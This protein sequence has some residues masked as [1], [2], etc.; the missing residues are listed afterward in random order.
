MAK[1]LKKK[2]MDVMEDFFSL[3]K[4]NKREKDEIR[5]LLWS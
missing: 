1:A 4:T 2:Y 5:E 3:I